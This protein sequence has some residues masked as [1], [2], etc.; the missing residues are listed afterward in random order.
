MKKLALIFLICC[1][2][3]TARAQVV[4]EPLEQAARESRQPERGQALRAA[5][6]P[7][8][9]PFFDDFATVL[10]A[11]DP[12]RWINGGAYV[13][14]RYAVAPITKNVA[15]FDGL[16]AV[17]TPYAPGSVGS[18]PSDSLTSQ[19]ILL[20]NLNPADSVYL[21]FYWQSGGLG[22]IPD[23]TSNEQVYLQLEF[24]DNTGNWQQVW[25]Q[26]GVGDTTRFV[27]VFVGLREARFLH[28]AFQFRFRSVG[29]RNGLADVWNVDYVVLD[30]NRRRGQNSTRDIAISEGVSRL[31][32]HYTTMPV[33]QFLANPQGELA[34]TVSAT[35]N[36]LGGLP[37]A[38]SW[39]GSI[40]RKDEPAGT[41]F[42]NQQAL[43]PG[44]ARQYPI[45]GTPRLDG[46]NLPGNAFTLVHGIWL[47][48]KEQDPLQR[49]NDSTQ[50]E[51]VFADYYAYD[52]GSAEAG[53]SFVASGNTQVAQRFDLNQPGQLKA[54]RVYFPRVRTNLAGTSIT[55]R[56]WDDN[57]GLP[58]ET[59][60]QQSFQIQYSD[61]LNEFYEVELSKLVP[62]TG[63]FYIGWS[64][65]GNLF[66]NI[67]FDR[68][69]HSPGRRFLFTALNGWVA[70]TEF[71]GA[72]MLRPVLAGDVLG[73][74]EEKLAAS[75]RLYPNPAHGRVYIQGEYESLVIYDVMGRKVHEQRYQPED[76]PLSLHKLAPG[77]YTFRIQN[78]E[79]T[80][81]KKLILK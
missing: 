53:F 35:L 73:L 31:L 46:L 14:N 7:L 11:P 57:N 23:K 22:D 80:I 30:K 8:A 72:L 71:K 13:N 39:Q 17:G 62:V 42:L 19:P 28:D 70:E 52:D 67:G 37:G 47:D 74:E 10:G 48:T 65:P 61:T 41:I 21:S 3:F 24:K 1:N 79:T 38:I 27:Q 25:R 36:N 76:Q 16:N 29:Q 56:V 26:P 18:G 50:R 32:R 9:L 60:H 40:R 64:Q 78:K 63:S 68:N 34:E 77:L 12:T 58:G 5:A 59:L 33:K 2:G 69:E 51:T 49:A 66:I 75:I 15:T 54:F 6:A 55:F 44:G 43:V 81:T 45:A 4:L 20:G